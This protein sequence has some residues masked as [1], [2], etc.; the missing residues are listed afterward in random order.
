MLSQPDFPTEWTIWREDGEDRA[1]D[2]QRDDTGAQNAIP[3]GEG[4]IQPTP[5]RPAETSAVAA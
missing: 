1:R 2:G 3:G 5:A 4:D